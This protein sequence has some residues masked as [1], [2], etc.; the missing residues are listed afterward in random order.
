MK[1]NLASSLVDHLRERI[2]SGDIAAGEKLPSE[3]TLIASHGVSRTV[4]REAITRLQAEGLIYTRRGAGSFALTPPPEATPESQTHIPRTLEERRQLIEYRLGFETEAAASAALRATEADL[5]AMD[6]ALE[7]FEASL[8]NASVSM[9]C[10]FEFH[11]AV[12]RATGNPYFSQAVQNFGPAM[13]AMP[14]RRMDSA[15]SVSSGRLDA[16]AA[17]HRAIHKAIAT[18]NPQLASAAMRIHLSNS[19]KRLQAEA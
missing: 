11:L 4:V 6:A 8:G 19:M 18:Q 3:N 10:D 14:R 9:S 16:V 5:N 15:D 2:S 1:P 12:A 17:E 7:G 13:I